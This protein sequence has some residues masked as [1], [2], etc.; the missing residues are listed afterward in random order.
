MILIVLT[1]SQWKQST[2]YRSLLLLLGC[3]KVDGDWKTLVL[4]EVTIVCLVSDGSICG[5]KTCYTVSPY[6][7]LFSIVQR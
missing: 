1:V 3:G 2:D 5:F 4:F 6:L 7:L